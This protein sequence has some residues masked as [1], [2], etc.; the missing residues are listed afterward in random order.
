MVL[1]DAEN[2]LNLGMV[3]S[4]KCPFCGHSEIGYTTPEGAFRPLKPGTLITVTEMPEPLAS[5][6]K[7]SPVVA[8]FV[9]E[10]EA[11]QGEFKPWVP[12]VLKGN[13]SLRVK[14]GVVVREKNALKGLTGDEYRSAF[15]R[16]IEKL[17]ETEVHTPLPILL[18]RFFAA[19]HLASGNPSQISQAIWRELEE[20]RKPVLLVS[21][22]LE[23]QDQES[24]SKMIHPK[25]IAELDEE[26]VSGK[27]LE[28]E[29]QSLTLEEF[30]EML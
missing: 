15:L 16:K 26:P 24:L 3:V 29:L 2:R 4:R 5:D 12:D 6:K 22:W 11:G 27:D 21:E 14:Y 13:H 9:G 28:A 17:I 25:P 30:L 23:K 19:P 8:D 7:D 1:K 18:D 20:I 10:Q